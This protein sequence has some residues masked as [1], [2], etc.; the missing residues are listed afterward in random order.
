MPYPVLELAELNRL[1][2]TRPPPS[3][4]RSLTPDD[5]QGLEEFFTGLHYFNRSKPTSITSSPA[6]TAS[7]LTLNDDEIGS[8]FMSDKFG[9]EADDQKGSIATVPWDETQGNMKRNK[10]VLLLSDELNPLAAPFVPTSN[11]PQQISSAIPP[12]QQSRRRVPAPTPPQIQPPWLSAF[13]DGSCV[14][15]APDSDALAF[16]LVSSCTW[17]MEAMGELAQHF[18]WKGSEAASADNAA[19]APFSLAVYRKFWDVHGE[20]IAKSFLWHLRE[21]VV[22][23]FLVCWDAVSTPS[24]S[25]SNACP[26][27][28]FLNQDQ[29]QSISYKSAPSFSYV[30]SALSLT[31]F[32]GKLFAQDLVTAH[33]AVTCLYLLLNN[34]VSIEHVQAIHSLLLHATFKLW[35]DVNVEGRANGSTSDFVPCF[36]HH[37]KLLKDNM[38]VLGKSLKPGELDIRIT[39]IVDMVNEWQTE[40]MPTPKIS[41]SG[42]HQESTVPPISSDVTILEIGGADV[43]NGEDANSN[44]VAGC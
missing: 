42:D 2:N 14:T 31:T 19:V 7:T 35:H 37:A 30:A 38:S 24:V 27:D 34:L 11:V 25:V 10:T 22:G 5:L 39:E 20:D 9:V 17:T 15:D 40:S 12:P 33:H 16:S 41:L 32:I 29:P 26:T 4:P 28:D 21:C 6:S 18:C 13:G 36:V 3:A 23:T 8:I 43:V 44:A 1:F